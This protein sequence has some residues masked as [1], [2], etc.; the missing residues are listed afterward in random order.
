MESLQAELSNVGA[1]NAKLKQKL[2]HLEYINQKNMNQLKI[3]QEMKY[4]RGK[5]S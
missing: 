3:Y 4:I 2:R 1:E 5:S